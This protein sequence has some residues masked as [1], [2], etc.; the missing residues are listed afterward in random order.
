MV[1]TY[2]RAKI[3]VDNKGDTRYFFD[4]G[5]EELERLRN[6]YPDA[7]MSVEKETDWGKY[8]GS[9]CPEKKLMKRILKRIIK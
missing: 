3:R 2:L 4:V 7:D 9:K 6:K 8:R 1:N 5:P